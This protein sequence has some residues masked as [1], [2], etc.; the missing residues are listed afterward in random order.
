MEKIKLSGRELDVMNVLW[1]SDK[2]L[3][4][5]EIS[6]R[7]SSLSINT[8]RMVVKGLLNKEF[9]KVSA[10]VYSGTVLTQSYEPVLNA[11][12]Y[13][14]NQITQAVKGNVSHVQVMAALLR[15]D[16]NEIEKLKKVRKE[17]GKRQEEAGIDIMHTN[18][19]P[20]INT[21]FI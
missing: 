2:A 16:E 15:Q 9:I 7:D 20:I 12:E 4:A 13:M 17:K 14:I 1:E 21:V 19:V 10:I 5:K 8:V 6:E 3:T 11:Q 18:I